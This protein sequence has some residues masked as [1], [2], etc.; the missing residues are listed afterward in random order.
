MSALKKVR[1][2]NRLFE[3]LAGD[4]AP[5]WAGVYR[6]S[7]DANLNNARRFKAA[8]EPHM[9][10]LFVDFARDDDRKYLQYLKEIRNR[11]VAQAR[12]QSYESHV[13]NLIQGVALGR[14]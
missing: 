13:L 1:T 6:T 11:A 2:N 14:R 5:Y 4:S 7:R 8:K 3:L 9:V 12:M 10:R